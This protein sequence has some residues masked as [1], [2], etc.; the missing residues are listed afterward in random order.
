MISTS[1]CLICPLQSGSPCCARLQAETTL[2]TLKSLGEATC[3]AALLGTF[4]A[5]GQGKGILDP[6]LVALLAL[7]VGAEL[8]A[9]KCVVLKREFEFTDWHHHEQN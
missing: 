4:A 8:A 5:L 1:Q 7:A 2:Q 3:L 9:Q 6:A